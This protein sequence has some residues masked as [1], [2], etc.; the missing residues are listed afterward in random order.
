MEQKNEFNSFSAIQFALKWRKPLL[1]ITLLSGILAFVFSLFITP[2]YKSTAIVFAPYQNSIM[3]E[4]Y[5][6]KYDMKRYGQEY[7]TEQL[8]QILNSRDF[9]DTL[10]RQL[11]LIEHYGINM[12]HKY[13]KNK[14]YEELDNIKIKRTQFGGISISVS[15]RSPQMAATLA[16]AIIDNLDDF[17]NRVE[18]ERSLA[19]CELLQQQIDDVNAKMLIVNDSVQ[20][21]ANEGLFIYDLQVE[22]VMQQYTIALGQGNVAGAQRIQKEID[23]ISKWGPTSVV[24][25]EEL[26]YLIRRETQL[27][28]LLWNSEMNAKGLIPNKYVVER[29]IPDEKKVYPKK[30]VITLFS[31]LGAFFVTFFVLLAIEKVKSG[32]SVYKKEE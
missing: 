22:R 15:D 16:N 18:R 24:L 8:L 21:L 30:S 5:D 4:T 2:M 3:V 28:T 10:V 7:E 32:I 17:K 26:I 27:K 19:T 14:L 1:I 6:V 13:W 31:A 20:K 23:K 11:N 12:Q 9:K 29:A 25:R